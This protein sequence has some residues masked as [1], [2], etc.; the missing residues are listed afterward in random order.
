MEN[1]IKGSMHE[2]YRFTRQNWRG[3]FEVTIIPVGV[4][5]LLTGGYLLVLIPLFSKIFALAAAGDNADPALIQ[6]MIATVFKVEMFAILASLAAA[7][8]MALSSV[9]IVR[10][11][12]RGERGLWAMNTDIAKAAGMWA[13]YS[14]G[15]YFISVFA[16]VGAMI[17][18]SII[19]GIVGAIIAAA[20]PSVVGG[21]LAGLLGIAGFV[22]MIF[23]LFA[24]LLRFA[25]GMPVVALG[26]T[27]DFFSE[28][29]KQS[30]GYTVALAGR[31][32]GA[33]LL[34][35]VCFALLIGVFVGVGLFLNFNAISQ[36][37]GSPDPDQVMSFVTSFIPWV[38]ASQVVIIVVSIPVYWFAVVW[39]TIVNKRLH[40]NRREKPA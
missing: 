2:A 7:F 39:L 31:A 38:V 35:F 16:M 20:G 30:K 33:Y 32:L 22:G 24:I 3:L 1:L 8:I 6:A 25:S 27:P 19:M 37:G 18:F 21:I 23:T 5:I 36:L 29:W 40:Q 9:R 17:P 12:V 10:F 15:I 28:M 11:F 34:I 13:L 14:I 26:Q 4:A